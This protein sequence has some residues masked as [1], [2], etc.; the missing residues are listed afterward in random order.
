MDHLFFMATAVAAAGLLD[1]CFHQDKGS[2]N[3]RSACK[4]VPHLL[5]QRKNN[6]APEKIVEALICL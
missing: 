3:G 2:K 5:I 6:T 1:F 4:R